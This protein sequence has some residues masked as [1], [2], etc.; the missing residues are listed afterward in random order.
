MRRDGDTTKHIDCE[1][2]KLGYLMASID[3][4]IIHKNF[5]SLAQRVSINFNQL[6][7]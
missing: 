5:P 3:C 1:G 4:Q 6:S 2:A 7:P